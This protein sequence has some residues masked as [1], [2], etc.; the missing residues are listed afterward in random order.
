M[1]DH[2]NEELHQVPAISLRDYFAAAALTGLLANPTPLRAL[3]IDVEEEYGPIEDSLAE[4]AY[5]MAAW[6][7]AARKEDI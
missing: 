7:L 6:M 3:L 5:V 4:A 2:Q 1:S